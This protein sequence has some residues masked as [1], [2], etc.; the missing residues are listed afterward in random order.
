MINRKPIKKKNLWFERLIALTATINLGLVFFNITYIG[1]RD[2][3]LRSLPF[4]QEIYDPIKGIEP[5]RETENYLRTIEELESLVG[6]TEQLSA[7]SVEKLEEL[8]NLSVEM[9]ENN[10]FAAVSKSGTLEKIKN[11]MRE[12]LDNES[13]KRAFSTFWTQEYL[14]RQGLDKELKFFNQKIKPLIATNYYRSIGENGEF[15]D[16]FWII[17]LPFVILFVFILLARS[18]YV[19][20]RHPGFSWLNAILWHWYDLFLVLPFWRWLRTIPVLFRLEKAELLNLQSLRHQA[21]QGIVANFAEEITQIVVVR[22]INQTQSSVRRGDLTRWLQQSQTLSPYVDINNVNEIEALGGIFVQTII[23]QVMPKIQ[24]EIIALLQHNIDS[25]FNQ[26]P[27]YRNFRNLP[28]FEQMQTQLSQ[29]LATSIATNLYQ[30]LVS[31]AEDPVSAELSSQLVKRFSESLTTEIQKKQVL[32]EIQ[33]LLIDFLEEIKINY[34][35]RLSEE[36]VEQILEQTRNLY[37]GV[38]VPLLADTRISQKAYPYQ[39][40][41]E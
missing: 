9:I 34:V 38:P 6:E 12:H 33:K 20:R 25:A 31:A 2:F 5:H 11:R 37:S 1:W 19:K 30:A 32:S 27:I 18:Y 4:I 23:H 26:S 17:D 35:Q 24:P 40:R 15:I 28:G 41:N 39:T 16:L 21:Q 10:P 8:R 14:L 29:Q 13:S 36:D 3:Y 22:V 7:E